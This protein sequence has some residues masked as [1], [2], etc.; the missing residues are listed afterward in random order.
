MW[1]KHDHAI[2]HAAATQPGTLPG[3]YE[4]YERIETRPLYSAEMGYPNVS[5]SSLGPWEL[6]PSVSEP[7][8]V[9]VLGGVGGSA[10]EA[11]LGALDCALGA[12][13]V[14][15]LLSALLWLGAEGGVRLQGHGRAR[16]PTPLDCKAEPARRRDSA[17]RPSPDLARGGH[18]VP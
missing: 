2:Q 4:I 14:A 15:L 10:V 3:A 1:L 12:L 5:D 16:S 6:S 18:Q 9:F 7:D 13:V 11:V 17:G 8:A